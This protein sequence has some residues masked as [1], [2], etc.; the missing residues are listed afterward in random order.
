MPKTRR[1]KYYRNADTAGGSEPRYKT[2]RKVSVE[3]SARQ[4][5]Q[6]QLRRLSLATCT[7]PTIQQS[8]PITPVPVAPQPEQEYQHPRRTS[9]LGNLLETQEEATKER[10]SFTLDPPATNAANEGGSR[11]RVSTL[12]GT[13]SRKTLTSAHTYQEASS[14]S[15][16]IAKPD[17]EPCGPETMWAFCVY[18]NNSGMTKVELK[19]GKRAWTLFY[20]LLFTFMWPF[21]LLPLFCKKCHE[22][23]H[24]CP[25]CKAVLSPVGRKKGIEENKNEVAS[26]KSKSSKSR[27]Q[28]QSP[29]TEP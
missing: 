1:S 6:G 5:R 26:Q 8:S 20:I 19:R 28:S 2:D 25:V 3:A 27:S 29:L 15:P 24:T 7:Q 14:L 21:C 13:A 10:N 9:S 23:V 17:T 16:L 11:N 4:G 12:V 22:Y 18:C